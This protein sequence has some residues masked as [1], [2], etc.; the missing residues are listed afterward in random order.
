MLW[1]YQ[2]DVFYSA[3]CL[4]LWK[5]EQLPHAHTD[6]P[7]PEEYAG[8]KTEEVLF[9]N[10][11]DQGRISSG[12]FR[13][14]WA[15][16]RLFFGMDGLPPRSIRKKSCRDTGEFEIVWD[17][18]SKISAPDEGIDLVVRCCCEKGSE[19]T[20]SAEVLILGAIKMLVNI[21]PHCNE[22][23]STSLQSY[24]NESTLFLKASG[25]L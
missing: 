24:F 12:V 21:L 15:R 1:L 2:C 10:G 17:R 13:V 11:S 20:D 14:S 22:S 3:L 23:V 4:F 18:N 9:T 19:V 25:I 16:T 8:V 7:A 5:C 6:W